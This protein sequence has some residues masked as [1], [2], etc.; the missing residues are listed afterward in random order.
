MKPAEI[1]T[2]DFH[3]QPI[4]R[5]RKWAVR[6]IA[7]ALLAF[8]LSFCFAESGPA[9]DLARLVPSDV[10][11]LAGLRQMPGDVAQDAL[12]LATRNNTEDLSRFITLTD[13]DPDRRVNQVIVAAWPSQKDNFGNHVLIAKGQFKFESVS[14]TAFVAGAAITDYKGVRIVEVP[15]ADHMK[16]TSRWLVVLGHNIAVY[17][18]PAAVRYALDR[19]LAKAPLDPRMRERLEYAYTHDRAWSSVQVDSR[20]VLSR[21]SFPSDD[22]SMLRCL[23]GVRDLQLGIQV[24][25]GVV[26]DL[27]TQPVANGSESMSNECLATAFF[28][29]ELPATH[30]VVAGYDTSHVRFALS[31]QAYDRWLDSFRHS[32]ASQTLF[33]MTS[34]P[35]W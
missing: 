23:A 2:R 21:V 3:S 28:G 18:T 8:T 35:G 14:R 34:G 10:P 22:D 5:A 4:H 27:R 15:S 20:R 25:K 19:H 29:K 16:Q 1:A 33:A 26:I 11:V 13:G 7:G 17:G 9:N 31:R 30:A 6:L 32:R 12:W 24:G